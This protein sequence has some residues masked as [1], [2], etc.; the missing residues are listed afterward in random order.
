MPN[1]Q[2]PFLSMFATG[3]LDSRP[4]STITRRDRWRC[5]LAEFASQIRSAT[6]RFS[7]DESPKILHR[8][9]DIEVMATDAGSISA[10]SDGVDPFALVDRAMNTIVERLRQRAGAGPDAGLHRRSA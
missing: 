6:V 1:T 7:N 8:R 2:Q 9:C 3:A 4:H 5:R 10:S